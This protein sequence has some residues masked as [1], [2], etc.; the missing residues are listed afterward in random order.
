M[1][2]IY[3]YTYMESVIYT[4]IYMVSIEDIDYSE[5]VGLYDLYGSVTFGTFDS[6]EK[7]YILFFWEKWNIV[8][9]VNAMFFLCSYII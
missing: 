8:V 4:Y 3:L 2:I 7:E 5:T 1:E 6:E 9:K